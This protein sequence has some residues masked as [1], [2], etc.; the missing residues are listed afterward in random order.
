MTMLGHLSSDASTRPHRRW[1]PL[2]WSLVAGLI[3]VAYLAGASV[4][5]SSGSAGAIL[6][7]DGTCLQTHQA[8]RWRCGVVDTEGS[9]GATYDVN[10]RVDSSCWDAQMVNDASEGGMPARVSGCV[11]RSLLPLPELL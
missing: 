7:Y 1:R 4:K 9:G 6:D 11:E 8:A 2:R 5:V 3:G 10:V